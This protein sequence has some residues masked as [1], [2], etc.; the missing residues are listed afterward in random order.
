[1]V[2][3]VQRSWNAEQDA[4]ARE[5]RFIADA[6][7]QLRTPLTALKSELD[8]ALIGPHEVAQLRLALESAREETDRICRL[9]D[10]LLLLAQAENAAGAANPQSIDVA[11]LSARPP[12]ATA[13]AQTAWTDRSR[14]MSS[15]VFT[16]GRIPTRSRS[17][18][19]PCWRTR[20]PTAPDP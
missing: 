2:V 13:P 7:H 17:H 18:S 11:A 16:S 20:S 3:A 12:G 5:R 9:A 14:C 8:V 6:S 4:I 10:D 1:M 19:T 15:P